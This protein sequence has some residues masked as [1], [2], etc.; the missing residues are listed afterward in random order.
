[1]TPF[2]ITMVL[3]SLCYQGYASGEILDDAFL[4]RWSQ[5]RTRIRTAG[6]K[7]QTVNTNDILSTVSGGIRRGTD[8]DGDLDLLLTVDTEKLQGWKGGDLLCLRSGSVW[9]ES[10][11]KRGRCPGR[12]QHWRPQ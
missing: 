11:S 5:L 8:I 6:V 2:A 4:A 1:M 12:Q 9:N 10:Q 3:L 7:L